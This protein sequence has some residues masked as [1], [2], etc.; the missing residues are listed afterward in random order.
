MSYY[1]SVKNSNSN[2]NI[3]LKPSYVVCFPWFNASLCS[4]EVVET[5]YCS[6]MVSLVIP[7]Y[8]YIIVFMFECECVLCACVNVSRIAFLSTV[9]GYDLKYC[10]VNG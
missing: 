4:W 9:A 5:L 1:Q 6:N 7:L 8:V 3:F 2:V 10:F